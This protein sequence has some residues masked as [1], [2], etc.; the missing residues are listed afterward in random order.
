MRKVRAEE[1]V[2]GFHTATCIM[3]DDDGNNIPSS[4]PPFTWKNVNSR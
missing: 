1:R 4:N 3:E 2:R